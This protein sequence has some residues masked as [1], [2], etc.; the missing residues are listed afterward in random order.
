MR[1]AI[2]VPMGAP[3]VTK[4]HEVFYRVLT[5]EGEQ[6]HLDLDGQLLVASFRE[7]HPSYYW[8]RGDELVF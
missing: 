7:I 6:A 8:V 5:P 2:D 1:K 3:F 4:D